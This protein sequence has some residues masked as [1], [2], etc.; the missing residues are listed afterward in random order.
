MIKK[1][2]YLLG[3]L[4]LCGALASIALFLVLFLLIPTRTGELLVGPWMASIDRYYGF[5]L[6]VTLLGFI[7]GLSLQK[8]MRG[9]KGEASSRALAPTL[10][11]PSAGDLFWFKIIVSGV[12][13][14]SAVLGLNR[15]FD[16]D[17]IARSS[18][19]A[20]GNYFFVINPLTT[21]NHSLATT[22]ALISAKFFGM[23]KVGLRAPSI[24][25][26]A[27]FLVVL[28]SFSKRYLSRFATYL[29]YGHLAV[30][31]LFVWYNHS[32]RGYISMLLFTLLSLK[33]ALDILSLSDKVSRRKL[34]AFAAAYTVCFFTHGF[35][36][37]F[38]MLLCLTVLAWLLTNQ[39]RLS[40]VQQDNG[41]L[42]LLTCLGVLA[43]SALMFVAHLQ[44]LERDGWLFHGG[45]NEVH[46]AAYKWSRLML[47]VGGSA[48]WI[49]K[50][51][52]LAAIALT[53]TQIRRF[54]AAVTTD[55]IMLFALISI[56]IISLKFYLLKV[57][58]LE[59]RMVLAFLVPVV[60]WLGNSVLSFERRSSRL[61]ASAL[62][63][64]VLIVP[65]IKNRENLLQGDIAFF[66]DNEAFAAEVKR[67][68]PGSSISCLSFSGEPDTIHYLRSFYLNDLAPKT[69]GCTKNYHIHIGRSQFGKEFPIVSDKSFTNYQRIFDDGKGRTLYTIDEGAPLAQ[70]AQ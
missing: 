11:T 12:I 32:M 56:S 28:F 44:V 41:S 49:G 43:L 15:P 34:G 45:V 59:G 57:D 55:F 68:L 52:S 29:V 48:I 66:Q 19:L 6:F 54:R 46:G 4:S 13:L 65:Q 24:F 16:W 36:G 27:M 8:W 17:E 33:L 38:A 42:L 50:I 53:V 1:I 63:L 9:E 37:L 2:E 47:L 51:L 40:A 26:S 21:L 25:V 39:R 5:L 22:L 35:G 23:T 70:L 3:N 30:N 14:V 31:G 58:L 67:Q 18:E 20:D 10:V 60:A 61:A 7:V 69:S 64:A 62:L